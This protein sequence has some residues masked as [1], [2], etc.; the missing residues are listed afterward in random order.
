MIALAIGALTLAA[1][2][3]GASVLFFRGYDKAFD[4][5]EQAARERLAAREAQV[6]VEAELVVERQK[7]RTAQARE[8]LMATN[9]SR[10]TAQVAAL[11]E[12]IRA[13]EVDLSKNMDLPAAR[14]AVVRMLELS[15]SRGRP[16]AVL[17]VAGA[18]PQAGRPP[19]V[20]T[21][22]TSDGVG[23]IDDPAL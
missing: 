1:L 15:R 7:L 14:A 13:L 4:K 9:N 19:G 16:T 23:P 21:G 12:D 11:E 2:A 10:L 5:S 17:P 22:A 6:K 18:L 8:K 20:S 3:V